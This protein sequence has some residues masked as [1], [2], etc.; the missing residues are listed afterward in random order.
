MLPPSP[1]TQPKLYHVCDR[2]IMKGYKFGEIQP[3]LLHQLVNTT[4]AGTFTLDDFLLAILSNNT[5]S[6][7]GTA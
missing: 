7:G 3:L 4:A 5:V 1:Q 2:L 6:E